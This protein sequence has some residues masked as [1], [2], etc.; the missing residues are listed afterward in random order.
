MKFSLLILYQ[1]S[2]GD[3]LKCINC[4]ALVRSDGFLQ[5]HVGDGS[6]CFNGSE[7]N[8]VDHEHENG[9]Q[10]KTVYINEWGNDWGSFRMNQSDLKR[11][12]THEVGLSFDGSKV[13]SWGHYWKDCRVESCGGFKANW[14][15]EFIDDAN[16]M[17]QSNIK[18]KNVIKSQR[19]D[20]SCHTCQAYSFDPNDTKLIDCM[21]GNGDG[22]SKSCNDNEQCLTYFNIQ[23][24]SPPGIGE[25][26]QVTHSCRK[27]IV[28]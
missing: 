27:Y 25:T 9:G 21:N 3:A 14:A 8:E 13:Y 6:A 11:I 7:T 4:H 28:I 10:C 18:S 19:Q 20:S 22:E 23:N 2:L 15:D 26:Y 17:I 1:F 12:W 24:M 16:D 5:G